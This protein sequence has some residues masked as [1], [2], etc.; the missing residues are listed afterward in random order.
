MRLPTRFSARCS[1]ASATRSVASRTRATSSSRMSVERR[2]YM[3]KRPAPALVRRGG[4]VVG[5]PTGRLDTAARPPVGH[6]TDVV[7][8]QR[9][10]LRRPG[11]RHHLAIA[12][13]G[14]PQGRVGEVIDQVTEEADHPFGL[15]AG[16]GPEIDPLEVERPELGQRR[17]RRFGHAH[18]AGLVDGVEHCDHEGPDLGRRFRADDIAHAV[19]EIGGR[20][21]T[22]PDRV[23]EVVADVGDAIGP[24]DHLT[25]GELQERGATVVAHAVGGLRTEVERRQGDVG[26]VD[27]VVVAPCRGGTSKTPP[28]GRARPRARGRS[29]GPGRWPP[30]VG[31]TGW[32]P[33]RSRRHL[34][35]SDRVE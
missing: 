22:G 13:R 7:H 32:R 33:G 20:E 28:P 2:C 14:D 5:P 29:R 16:R 30:P 3:P 9:G 26:A 8:R 12:H 4:K 25:F 24:G 11:D 15:P 35:H 34:G 31:G 27:R 18:R 19:G 17:R 10:G 23:V 6:P 21:E 1:L